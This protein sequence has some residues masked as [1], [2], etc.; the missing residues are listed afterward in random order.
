VDFDFADASADEASVFSC[1]VAGSGVAVP[2]LFAGSSFGFPAGADFPPATS[3]A[4]GS[5]FGTSAGVSS[6][7]FSSND[8]GSASSSRA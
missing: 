8:A 5:I 6:I 3:A 7:S 1:S 4:V 2:A